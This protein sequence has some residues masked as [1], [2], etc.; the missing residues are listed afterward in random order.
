MNR[1][2]SNRASDAAP[3]AAV[4]AALLVQ[5]AAIRWLL[6][7]DEFR[8]YIL[9]RPLVWECALRSHFG[10]P[11][12]T[13]GL[14]RSV[15]MALHGHIGR[16]WNMA[17]GGVSAVA[18]ALALAAGLVALGVA[19]WT[20]NP[21]AEAVRAGLR[22]GALLCAA[23]VVMVWMGGWVSG[24]AAALHRVDTVA[25]LHTVNG[26]TKSARSLLQCTDSHSR[27]Y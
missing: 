22:R 4:A 3:A 21:A 24:F 15:V 18:G 10:L 8:V 9:G 20:G 23:I 2:D 5:A 26:N 16:A 7:A 27:V 6:D 13:C 17:P 12:P 14:T 19:R 1:R 11:C 25:R